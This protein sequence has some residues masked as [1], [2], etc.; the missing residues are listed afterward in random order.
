MS[1][2]TVLLTGGCG[3]LGQHL[4]RDLLRE[5]PEVHLRIIDL[6]PNPFARFDF[7]SDN[8]VEVRLGLDIYDL[9]A[10]RDAFRGVDVV[11]HLAGLVSPSLKDRCS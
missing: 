6:Q 8:R 10:I 1:L 2:K 3:F 5:F 9:Q 4:V 7:S 11:V